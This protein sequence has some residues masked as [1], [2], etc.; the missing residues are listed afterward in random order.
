MR[1]QRTGKGGEN[2]GG[3]LA[4]LISLVEKKSAAYYK[5]LQK[6]KNCVDLK[7]NFQNMSEIV[8]KEAISCGIR[9]TEFLENYPLIV[10]TNLNCHSIRNR[11]R[12]AKLVE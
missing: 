10:K 1:T 4:T 9:A 8:D 3:Q 12:I 6:N 11:L 5:L 2:L 7:R